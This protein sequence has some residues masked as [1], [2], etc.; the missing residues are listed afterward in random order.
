MSSAVREEWGPSREEEQKK[1]S[2]LWKQQELLKLRFQ[3]IIR[4][5][6]EDLVPLQILESDTFLVIKIVFP[7]KTG[8]RER[9]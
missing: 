2:V 1:E 3:L 9:K 4:K 6:E 7:P 8:K 5:G